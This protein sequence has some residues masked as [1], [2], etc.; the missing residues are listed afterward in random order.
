MGAPDRK[1]KPD[2]AKL[3]RFSLLDNGRKID[4][5]LLSRF[6][7]IKKTFPPRLKAWETTTNS[8]EVVRKIESDRLP[9]KIGRISSPDSSIMSATESESPSK[10]S[11]I[12]HMPVSRLFVD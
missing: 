6:Q 5:Y 10:V 7:P 1:I 9:N 11:D 8:G 3:F 2:K 12:F 4:C